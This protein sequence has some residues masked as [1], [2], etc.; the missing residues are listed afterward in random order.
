MAYSEARGNNSGGGTLNNVFFVNTHN[1][2][3]SNELLYYSFR[4]STGFGAIAP[5]S[6]R[7]HSHHIYIYIYI[8]NYMKY[9]PITISYRYDVKVTFLTMGL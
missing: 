2:F 7:L 4:P 5:W 6:G 8:R 1:C 3:G 9:K